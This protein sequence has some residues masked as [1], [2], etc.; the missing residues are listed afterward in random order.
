MVKAWVKVVNTKNVHLDEVL[1][2]VAS[3]DQVWFR[4]YQIQGCKVGKMI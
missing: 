4:K 2:E 1:D 3:A